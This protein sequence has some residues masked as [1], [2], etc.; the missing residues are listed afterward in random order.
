MSKN[1][2][3]LA[4]EIIQAYSNTMRWYYHSNFTRYIQALEKVPLYIVEKQDALG[5]EHVNQKGIMA[6][7]CCIFMPTK[8]FQVYLRPPQTFTSHRIHYS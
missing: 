6:K 3:Q 8:S 2:P 4:E 7:K 1:Q 5:Y